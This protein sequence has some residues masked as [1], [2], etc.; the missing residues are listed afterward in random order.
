MKKIKLWGYISAS[1]VL[2]W[3]GFPPNGILPALLICFLPVLRLQDALMNESKRTRWFFYWTNFACWHFAT[4]WWVSNAH[5]IGLIAP[6]L[7]HSAILAFLLL[8]VDRIRLWK[9]AFRLPAFILSLLAFE[10][11]IISW[12][13]EFPWLL[14]GNGLAE[15][16]SLA[17]WYSI[18]GVFG[19]SLWLLGINAGVYQLLE[20]TEMKLKRRWL[21]G[22][23]LWVLI[24]AAL[25]LQLLS[26]FR[27]QT[28]APDTLAVTVFQPNLDP[29]GAKFR[30]ELFQLQLDSLLAYCDTLPSMSRL[31]IWPETSIPGDY[32]ITPQGFNWQNAPADSFLARH[33]GLQWMAGINGFRFFSP[34]YN[35]L[36][37]RTASNGGKY[38]MYNAAILRSRGQNLGFYNKRKRV[39]G[40]EKTPYLHALSFLKNTALDLGGM[41]GNLGDT[42]YE[43]LIKVNGI[44][45]VPIIC[46]ESV[47]PDLVAEMTREGGRLLVIMTND[48]WW[49]NTAGYRQHFLFARLRAIENRRWIARSANTG[50][51]GF[52]GPDGQ[53]F[54]QLP[55]GVRGMLTR[56]LPLLQTETYFTRHGD[57]VGIAGAS[58]F[59][60][61]FVLSMFI[62]P[63][64]SQA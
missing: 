16:T 46:Y 64:Q 22:L 56:N 1:T 39:V 42:P 54:E 3:A 58:L 59:M 50:I 21:I 45:V 30:P 43:G 32:D 62:K 33:S 48:G 17:Q 5:P 20:A 23:S 8:W 36:S 53:A 49:G 63:K 34:D 14:L 18:T 51:S 38:E 60:V 27:S 40:V 13:L 15:W 19:G 44:S 61:F 25:S 29:Y 28:S 41:A 52:I 37:A 6:L 55:W 4:V 12:D 24:P 31:L 26:Q 7:I 9:S 57:Q 47:F 11:L 2:F 35:S 10:K